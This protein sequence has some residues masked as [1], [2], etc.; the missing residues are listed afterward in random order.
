[1]L[2]YFI[3]LKMF[4][5]V[6]R[7]ILM[8]DLRGFI[9]Q[10]TQSIPSSAVG[11]GWKENSVLRAARFRLQFSFHP[12]STAEPIHR[13]SQTLKLQLYAV[14]FTPLAWKKPHTFE[15]IKLICEL[16][17]F[18]DTKWCTRSYKLCNFGDDNFLFYAHKMAALRRFYKKENTIHEFSWF[19]HNRTIELP[20]PL[21]F[22]K[23]ITC[24]HNNM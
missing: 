24:S 3:N 17:D 18:F 16:N 9:K 1:M 11:K 10:Y 15:A 8:S 23:A 13:L 4:V 19:D 14:W 5:P 12:F 2:H 22:Y 7:I 21:I 6:Q 20:D